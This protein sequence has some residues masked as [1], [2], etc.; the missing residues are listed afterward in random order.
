[1]PPK[2]RRASRGGGHPPRFAGRRLVVEV[3][4]RNS[5]WPSSASSLPMGLRPGADPINTTGSAAVPSAAIPAAVSR[6]GVHR[7]PGGSGARRAATLFHRFVDDTGNARSTTADQQGH[8]RPPH[9]SARANHRRPGRNQKPRTSQHRWKR[10]L[11]AAGLCGRR[12]ASSR[13]PLDLA[14]SLASV[15]RSKNCPAGLHENFDQR[16]RSGPSVALFG[17]SRNH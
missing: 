10:S 5:G 4:I 14:D 17:R 16:P 9:G 3:L 6:A 11:A 12:G 7:A 15:Y 13:R 1:M 8:R 2:W